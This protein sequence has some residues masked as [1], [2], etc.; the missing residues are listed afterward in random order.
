MLRFP[1]VGDF[2]VFVVHITEWVTKRFCSLFSSDHCSKKS[3]QVLYLERSLLIIRYDMIHSDSLLT[4]LF[5][6][7]TNLP[8]KTEYLSFVL[9]M[10]SLIYVGITVLVLLSQAVSLFD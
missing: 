4:V 10:T 6:R 5:K 9:P 3:V 1:E 8:L 7:V 2:D